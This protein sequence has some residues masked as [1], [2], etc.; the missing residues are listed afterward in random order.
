MAERNGYIYRNMNASPD[1]L[2]NLL[3]SDS[4][5]WSWTPA[6]LYTRGAQRNDHLLRG[7]Q[8]YEEGHALRQDM[9]IRWKAPPAERQSA[10]AGSKRYDVLLLSTSP[11]SR[12]GFVPIPPDGAPW[13]TTHSRMHL[14]HPLGAAANPPQDETRTATCFIAPDGSV[15]FVALLEPSIAQ[16]GTE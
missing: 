5:G 7:E 1:E 6:Y 4:T 13:R 2:R 10:E 12:P 3:A 9:E 8:E 15:Q 11:Q 16:G 14:Q